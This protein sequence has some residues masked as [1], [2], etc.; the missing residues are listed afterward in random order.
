MPYLENILGSFALTL[1]DNLKESASESSGCSEGGAI[2]LNQIGSEQ[3]ITIEDLRASLG[4]STHSAAT[5][6]VARLEADHLVTKF[7]SGE[8]SR[9]TQLALTNKGKALRKTI[10][11]ERQK[12][13]ENALSALDEDEKQALEGLIKKML[14]QMP[15]DDRACNRSCRFCDTR[16]CPDPDCPIQVTA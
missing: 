2:A 7:K 6:V 3:H 16:V 15:F 5:R 1:A 4:V 10:L 11:S 9:F 8:D 13:L 14:T 12:L